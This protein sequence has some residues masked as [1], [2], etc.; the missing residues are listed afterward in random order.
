MLSA[1]SQPL[2]AASRLMTQN[3]GPSKGAAGKTAEEAEKWGG[4]Q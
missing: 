3:V 1:P 4:W 2:M